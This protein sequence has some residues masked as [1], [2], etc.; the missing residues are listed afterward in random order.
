MNRSL[1]RSLFAA[2]LAVSTLAPLG[3]GGG[4]EPAP[5]APAPP[6][7]A[8]PVPA[9]EPTPAA[10]PAPA[11][12]AEGAATGAASP[13]ACIAGNAEA[14][15]AKYTMLC[16]SCHGATGA[17]DGVAS[18]G[19]NPKP[20][21]HNDGAYMNPLSNEH[22]VKVITEGGPAVGKSAGMAPWGAALGSQ[23]V[24]DVVAYVRTLADPPY[25][26]P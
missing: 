10:E 11:A 8:A 6:P 22:L 21:H 23:G 20:A 14:G 25:A 13:F 1:G 5:A 12:P 2:V 7:A 9:P 3:C 16:A 24:L 18:A 26:C 4:E 17:G 15:K 19:L